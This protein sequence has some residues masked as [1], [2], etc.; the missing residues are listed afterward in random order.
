MLVLRDEFRLGWIVKMI[1]IEEQNLIM[2]L[3]EVCKL[4]IFHGF[5]ICFSTFIVCQDLKLKRFILLMVAVL[6]NKC[7]K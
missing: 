3:T 1:E 7:S 5:L 6:L 4:V 2:N